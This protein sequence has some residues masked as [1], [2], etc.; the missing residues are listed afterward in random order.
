[1]IPRRR[2][3]EWRYEQGRGYHLRQY[4]GGRPTGFVAV[5][6][7]VSALDAPW[8]DG[9]GL[10]LV[11]ERSRLVVEEPRARGSGPSALLRIPLRSCV[12]AQLSTEVGLPGSTLLRL[13]IAFRLGREATVR[14]PLWFPV[15]GREF[16]QAL[17][18]E[19]NGPG[20]PAPAPSASLDQEPDRPAATVAQL[21][22]RRA[23]D[24]P[25]W[26]VFR[27]VDDGEVV[28][29]EDQPIVPIVPPVGR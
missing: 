15:Q 13:S 10:R 25:E 28:I 6:S 2:K 27:S 11:W 21:P 14:I 24:D 19:I 7:H 12:G 16:L 22:V 18:T 20:T 9:V 8:L 4:E 17:V 26:L 29:A 3:P 23:P 1:M 5:V